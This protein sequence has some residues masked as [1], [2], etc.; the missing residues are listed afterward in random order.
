MESNFVV[1][2]TVH[3]IREMSGLYNRSLRNTAFTMV[4]SLAR[5][6]AP[7]RDQFRLTRIGQFVEYNTPLDD[8]HSGLAFHGPILER[9]IF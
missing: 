8:R 9:C 7:G 3:P 6:I 4:V 2:F 5:E 1:R